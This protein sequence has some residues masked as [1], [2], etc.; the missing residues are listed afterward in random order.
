MKEK[1]S[2]ELSPKHGLNPSLMKCLICGK[3]TSIA[4][5]GKLKD[6]AEAPKEIHNDICDE[7]QKIIDNGGKFIIEVKDNTSHENPYRTGRLVAVSTQFAERFKDY[8]TLDSIN[9]MEESGF[10]Q[11]FGNQFNKE[12]KENGEE[13]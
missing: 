7:C 2:I 13:K 12:I 8:F 1:D 10:D 6:D 11:L 5:F 4:L 3:D 9:Y